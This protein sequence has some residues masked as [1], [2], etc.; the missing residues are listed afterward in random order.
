LLIFSLFKTHIK[1]AIQIGGGGTYAAIG[2]RAFLPD[3][4]IAMLVDRGN[5]FPE[6]VQNK[7]DSY[8]QNMWIFRNQPDRGTTRALNL[9][10]G[11]RRE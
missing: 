8:G 5:D 3:Y 4:Q 7:L 6:Q 2:A 1:E 9:Y 10:H 11:E